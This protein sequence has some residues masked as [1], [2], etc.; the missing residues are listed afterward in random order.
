VSSEIACTFACRDNEL[1]GICHP[2]DCREPTRG[3]VIVVGGPQYRV[4]SHRQFLLLAR[5]LAAQGIPVFRFDYSGMGDASGEP[6]T[7]EQIDEDINAAVN[8]FKKHCSSI[9][10][11]VLWGLCDAA[12]AVLFYAWKDPQIAGLVLLNPWVRTEAG[13]ARAYVKHYYLQRV[14]SRDFWHKI[15]SGGFNVGPAWRGFIGNLFHTAALDSGCNS[16]SRK[17]SD[18]LEGTLPERMAKGVEY[19]QGPILFIL[20]DEDLTAAEFKDTIKSSRNWRKLMQQP[21]ISR[22]DIPDANHTFASCDWRNLVQ[23]KT[24]EWIKQW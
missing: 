7:F 13:I 22:Y 12:S 3:V 18:R 17:T 11:V 16:L 15:I 10:E 6:A 4:G 21:R 1:I 24:V 19:F 14:L 5:A 23:D 20:S 9:K 2:G 8:E